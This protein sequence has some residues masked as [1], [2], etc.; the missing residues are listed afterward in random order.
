MNIFSMHH[1]PHDPGFS[2][3]HGWHLWL[4]GS[5][6]GWGITSL[7]QSLL[8]HLTGGGCKLAT[9]PYNE[10]SLKITVPKC[11]FNLG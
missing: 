7:V 4:V 3:S 1:N 11:K 6:F 10:N 8:H 5:G 2:H 9:G